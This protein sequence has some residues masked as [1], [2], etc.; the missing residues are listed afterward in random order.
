[1]SSANR[2]HG[3][4]ACAYTISFQRSPP[5]PGG[6]KDGWSHSRTHVYTHRHAHTCVHTRVHTYMCA[7]TCTHTGTHTRV[8]TQA[9]TYV[10]SHSLEIADAE[11][12]LKQCWFSVSHL[13][14]YKTVVGRCS[15][16]A[17]LAPRAPGGSGCE[18]RCALGSP[19][20]RTAVLLSRGHI[21]AQAGSA[22]SCRAFRRWPR[23]S[24]WVERDRLSLGL[25]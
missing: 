21:A 7:H 9:R 2:R 18:A 5:L 20:P 8:H 3:A 14:A 10:C 25:L 15:A 13:R 16:G 24:P 1:M 19:C 23:R 17:W 6:C 22:S 11:L 4:E 12:A